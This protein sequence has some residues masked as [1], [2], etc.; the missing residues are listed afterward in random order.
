[1]LVSKD[2]RKKIQLVIEKGLKSKEYAELRD[3]VYDLCTKHCIELMIVVHTFASC[4]QA[5]QRFCDSQTE[6]RK[7]P[8]HA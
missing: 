7:I 4:V 6:L 8:K 5:F 1:M 3:I 2:S